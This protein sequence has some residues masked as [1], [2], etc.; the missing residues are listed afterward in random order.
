VPHITEAYGAKKDSK[1]TRVLLCTIRNC[2]TNIDHVIEWARELFDSL[3]HELPE[4][5]V[6][7]LSNANDKMSCSPSVRKDVVAMN[8]ALEW[9]SN[10][11]APILLEAMIAVTIP[12]PESPPR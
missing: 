10:P 8:A 9:C 6:L 5:V 2:R 4:N 7:P 1:E 12:G 3:F 11:T